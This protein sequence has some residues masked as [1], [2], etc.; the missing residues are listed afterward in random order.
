VS[1]HKGKT[2]EQWAA[3]LL[4][5]TGYQIV[6]RNFSCYQGEID[7]IALNNKQLIFVEVKYRSNLDYGLAQEHI[8]ASKIKRLR[9]SAQVFLR[10]NPKFSSYACRFDVIVVNQQDYKWL[11]S[12]F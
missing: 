12:A 1:R 5:N 7:I 10:Q 3:K 9:I 6:K 4:K 11:K 8:N 2:Y